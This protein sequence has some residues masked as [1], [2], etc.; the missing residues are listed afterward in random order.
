MDIH[1]IPLTEIDDA[2]LPR[3]RT[4]L[5]P[6]PLRELRDSIVASGLR[7]PVELFPLAHPHGDV[8]Y[9]IVSG[10]RRITAFRELHA[11]WGLK[12]YAAIPA[13]LREPPDRAAVIAAMVEENAVRATSRR[14]SR[15]A[16]PSTPATTAATAPSRK[17]SPASTPP[18]TR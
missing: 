7:M 12:D 15:P 3:D 2:A 11:T 10:F 9:G 13:F 17:P 14:G 18:P 1:L 5:D 16:S 4:G 8:R 6:E